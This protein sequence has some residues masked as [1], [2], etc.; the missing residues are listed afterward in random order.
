MQQ[1]KKYKLNLIEPDDLFLA[2][3]LNQSAQKIED[4]LAGEEAARM[5]AD[6]ALDRRVTVLE[7]RKMAY[8]SYTG[9]GAET[10]F[11]PLPFTPKA[12]FIQAVSYGQRAEMTVG[13]EPGIHAQ[14]A[15]G[16][17]KA[18]LNYTTAGAIPATNTKG[19]RYIY[20]ALC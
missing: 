11:I 14:L 4:T 6:A 3:G 13:A 16:G 7:G 15:E 2:D 5:S 19:R 17:F 1:T 8:G 10:Q 18:L 20:L 9:D 12:L